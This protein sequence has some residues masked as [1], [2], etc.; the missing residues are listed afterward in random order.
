MLFDTFRVLSFDC[1][2]T[3]IDWESGILET[4]RPVLSTHRI[5][6]DDAKILEAYAEIESREQRGE[7]GSGA[8]HPASAHPDLEV[9]DLKAMV[10]LI[11]SDPG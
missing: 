1:Y 5:N 11:G 2:G 8:T 6:L 10:A 9:P 7:E 4:L 3:P